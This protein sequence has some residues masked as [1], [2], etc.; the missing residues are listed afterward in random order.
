VTR[1][2]RSFSCC[3]KQ[4]LS[5]QYQTKHGRVFEELGRKMQL[6]IPEGD[7]QF[8]VG[9]GVSCSSS[10]ECVGIRPVFRVAGGPEFCVNKF[11]EQ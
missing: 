7:R 8:A 1:A 4:L 10:G 6:V 2:T 9:I 5:S 11:Y 3:F